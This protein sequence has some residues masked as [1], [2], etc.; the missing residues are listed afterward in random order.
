MNRQSLIEHVEVDIEI[1]YK[2]PVDFF[3]AEAV[4]RQI[5]HGLEDRGAIDETLLRPVLG[6]HQG[7]DFG[8]IPLFRQNVH[9]TLRAQN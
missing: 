4:M 3:G 8:N 2:A 7:I 6:V 1:S 9:S 5:C